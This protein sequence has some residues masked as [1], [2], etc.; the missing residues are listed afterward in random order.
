MAD[1]RP[2]TTV[3]LFESTGVDAENQPLFTSEGAKLGWYNSHRVFAFE[4]YSYQREN[5]Q[6]IRVKAKAGDLRK[7]DML[8]FQNSGWKWIFCNILA[9]EFINPNCTEITFQTDSFATFVEDIEWCDCWI[10]REMQSQDWN[11]SIPSFNNLNPEG[12]ET[13]ILQRKETAIGETEQTNFS[14]VILSAYDINGEENYDV[15]SWNNYPSGLNIITFPIPKNGTISGLNTMLKAYADKGRDLS[16]CIAGLYVIPAPYAEGHSK[17]I[18]QITVEN[19]WPSIDGYTPINAKCFSS[20]FV[21]LEISNRMGNTQELRPEI[22]GDSPTLTWEG[23][24]GGGNGGSVLYP[25]KYDGHARDYGVIRYDNIQSPFVG[26]TYAS[27]LAANM[28]NLVIDTTSGVFN[29]II[30]GSLIGDGQTQSKLDKLGNFIP[31]NDKALIGTLSAVGGSLLA[32]G[33]SLAKVYEK[34]VSPSCIG[35]QSAG[36]V[37]DLVLDNYGFTVNWLHPVTPIWKSIDDFFSRFG[38]RTN[39]LKKPNVDTRPLWNYVKTAGG[40]VKGPFDYSDKIAIQKCLDNGVTLWHVPA[41]TI[42]DYS[43][44]AGNKE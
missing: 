2:E 35:G 29:S 19:P 39:R 15:R 41:A 20:E 40:V 1:F 24:L 12:I 32:V 38:Y 34:S 43:N 25:T 26:N 5:R 36:N 16:T 9:I 7:C 23:H 11:G 13:G 3:Y 22:L 17:V 4:N 18:K 37:L 10:E 30:G 28:G 42:G 44:M 21:R 6:Y 27:W 14:L 8:A 31:G 33:K